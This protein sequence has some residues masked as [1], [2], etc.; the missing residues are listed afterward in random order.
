MDND[1]KAQCRIM[2]EHF[3]AGKTTSTL[4]A[5]REFDIA[6][7]RARIRDLRKGIYDGYKWPIAGDWI[8]SK[9]GRHFKKYYLRTEQRALTLFDS[10]AFS[11]GNPRD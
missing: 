9:N 8:K 4:G 1:F 10:Q 6:D 3:K 11:W 7:P 2:L 5:M